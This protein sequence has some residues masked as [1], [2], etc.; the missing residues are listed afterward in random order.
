MS[1][2]LAHLALRMALPFW[3]WVFNDR[4]RCS[5][6]PLASC[7][8]S[9]PHCPATPSSSSYGSFLS[10]S[11]QPPPETVRHCLDT[12]FA[13]SK[14]RVQRSIVMRSPLSD[15]GAVT[16]RGLLLHTQSLGPFYKGDVAIEGEGRSAPVHYQGVVFGRRCGTVALRDGETKSGS[17][18]H[19]FVAR[20]GANLCLCVCRHAPA[21]GRRSSFLI[22]H[23]FFHNLQ[24]VAFGG[25]PR[26]VSIANKFKYL[27][28]RIVQ[29]SRTM[30]E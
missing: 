5:D 17:W 7:Y 24:R 20:A 19:S 23:S 13:R 27:S 1:D 2:G 25:W 21:V 15:V 12:P 6:G 28:I 4:G 10:L 29:A 26:R 9:I 11:A 18:F 14:G 3:S 16:Q 8:P 22:L 30:H